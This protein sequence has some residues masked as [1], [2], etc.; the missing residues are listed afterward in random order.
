MLLVLRHPMNTLTGGLHFST[1][2]MLR[3]FTCYGLPNCIAVWRQKYVSVTN[4]LSKYLKLNWYGRAAVMFRWP[5]RLI[6]F[7]STALNRL[8]TEGKNLLRSFN[9]VPF[10]IEK[11]DFDTTIENRKSHMLSLNTI[12]QNY[13]LLHHISTGEWHFMPL[14]ENIISHLSRKIPFSSISRRRTVML[15]CQH[16]YYIIPFDND[17]R[18]VLHCH[19]FCSGLRMTIISTD[20]YLIFRVLSPH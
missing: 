6:P 13:F 17:S 18:D 3:L 19:T 14:L 1:L 20:Q 2:M 9:K 8:L 15:K 12:L 16:V 10:Q 5:R 7:M 11:D 4:K